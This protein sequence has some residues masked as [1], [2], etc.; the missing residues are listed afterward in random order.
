VTTTT[1]VDDPIDSIFRLFLLSINNDGN[2]SQIKFKIN[3]VEKVA[4]GI[5]PKVIFEVMCQDFA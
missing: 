2:Q 3:H 5:E 4:M 1:A